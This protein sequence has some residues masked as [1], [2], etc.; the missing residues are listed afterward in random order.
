MAALNRAKSATLYTAIDG[1]GGYYTNKV[2]KSARSWMNAPFQLHDDA[3]DAAFLKEAEAAGL[4]ALKGH[5]AV[6]AM[7]ASLY[8]AMTMAGVEALT[9]FMTDFARRHG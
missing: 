6:G 3:L 1:S 8:N 4:S 2:E 5:R 7:R 9:G